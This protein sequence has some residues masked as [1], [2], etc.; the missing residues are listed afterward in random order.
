MIEQ[1]SENGCLTLTINRPDKANA[2]TEAML[3]QLADAVEKADAKVLVLTGAGKV[4]SAGA[5]L[6]DVRNGTLALSPEWERLSS[7]VAGFAGLS[8]AALNGSCAGGALGM[9][10]A[11]DLR[12]AVS[13]A[14]FFYPVIKMGVL[15]QPSDPARLA[16][17]VGP[18]VAKR[19]L[20]TGAKITAQ[21][22]HS[23]GLVDQISTVAV[24]TD[25]AALIEP[26][27]A[28]DPAQVMA[29]KAMIG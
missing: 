18:S 8:V 21:E 12:V 4:F 19:I 6:D 23:F 15:P 3:G 26:A 2:L 9:V 7:A 28:A 10:L 16:A 17:L 25:T 27:L 20:L 29:I 11:C 1:S 22:A 14:K 24:E 13:T 5:D